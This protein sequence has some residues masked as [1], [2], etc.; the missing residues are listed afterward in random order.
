MHLEPFSSPS[1]HTHIYKYTTNK[2][3]DML[4]SKRNHL[5][6]L[7]RISTTTLPYVNI[8]QWKAFHSKCHIYKKKIASQTNTFIF[9]TLPLFYLN[10]VNVDPKPFFDRRLIK[11]NKRYSN[12]FISNLHVDINRGISYISPV[13]V[14]IALL[15]PFCI[16]K[17]QFNNFRNGKS[18]MESQTIGL[19]CI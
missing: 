8:E 10:V 16:N 14:S 5:L 4:L 7:A 9:I 2:N 15:L 18:Y 3:K 17:L 1:P 11:I 12:C 19:I 6:S 13:A